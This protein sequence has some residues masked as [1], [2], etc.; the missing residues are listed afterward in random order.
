MPKLLLPCFLFL[1]FVGSADAQQDMYDKI[2][3]KISID[4]A[5]YNITFFVTTKQKKIQ[6]D[7]FYHWFKNGKIYVTQEGFSGRLLDQEYHMYYPSRSLCVDGQFYFGLQDGIWKY[8]DSAGILTKKMTWKKGLAD[9]D[10][11]LYDSIGA[12]KEKGNY[13]NGKLEGSY[14]LY[15]NG[16]PVQKVLYKN[17]EPIKQEDDEKKKEKENATSN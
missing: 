14:T 13:K 4:S 17:G 3:N 15:K 16:K 6:S 5:G 8:W 7:R 2:L 12:L 9:G 11:E 10:V 1:L